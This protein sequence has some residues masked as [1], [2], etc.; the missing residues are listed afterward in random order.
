M[1]AFNGNGM[2]LSNILISTKLGLNFDCSICINLHNYTT[3]R[4][5]R[6]EN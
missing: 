3:L 6:E 2:N 5:L 1:C 4:R